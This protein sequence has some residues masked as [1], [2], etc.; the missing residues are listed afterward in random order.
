MKPGTMLKIDWDSGQGFN[1]YER[2]R[3]RLDT[4]M[5][6]GASGHQIIIRRAGE[7]NAASQSSEVVCNRISIDN[8]DMDLT[9]LVSSEVYVDVS[10]LHFRKP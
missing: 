9:G 5:P 3:F 2:E 1:S 8:Q 6:E 7:K 10:G 4:V